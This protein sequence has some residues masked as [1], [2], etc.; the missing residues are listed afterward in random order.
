MTVGKAVLLRAALALLA[1]ARAKKAGI[2]LVSFGDGPRY[3]GTL[4]YFR[5]NAAHLGFT[6]TLLWGSKD[7]ERDPYFKR[8][9]TH[10]RH[11]GTRR[12][13][14]AGFKALMLWR[15]LESAG[16]G[17]YVF[18][19][20]ASRYFD[21]AARPMKKGIARRAVEALARG[22]VE[23]NQC[24]SS[25]IEQASR[26]WRDERA[27]NLISTQARGP[28]D[29]LGFVAGCG[30][31]TARAAPTLSHAFAEAPSLEALFPGV[32]AATAPEINTA[33]IILRNTPIN[34]ELVGAFLGGLASV[35]TARAVCKAATHQ[36]QALWSLLAAAR[37]RG[38]KETLS[39]CS[40]SK[41]LKGYKARNGAKDKYHKNFLAVVERLAAGKF[42]AWGG[43]VVD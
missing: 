27:V 8:N 2:T 6:A 40:C 11:M 37:G 10:L 16:E 15:A 21:Y 20:D 9:L 24:V 12:P 22:C 31:R 36:D 43:C 14:C 1:G 19:A 26:R 7:V 28:G 35:E 13:Y 41:T 5:R 25:A 34:R 17:D 33:H 38:K 42:V 29:A 18:W 30:T 39:I 23:I 3:E 4:A 32:D